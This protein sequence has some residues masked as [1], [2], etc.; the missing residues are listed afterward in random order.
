MVKIMKEYEIKL[1]S[2]RQFGVITYKYYQ[3]L[4][5]DG[6][7]E[8]LEKYVEELRKDSMFNISWHINDKEKGIIEEMIDTLD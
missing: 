5:Y 6:N 3:I 8:E 7:V 2:E 4:N 1:I